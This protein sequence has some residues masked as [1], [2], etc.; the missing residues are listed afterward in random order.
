MSSAGKATLS[1]EAKKANHIASEQKRR[2]Q[3][4]GEMDR[5]ARAVG[6]E[7][8]GRNELKVYQ[9]AVDALT[10]RQVPRFRLAYENMKR[11]AVEPPDFLLDWYE[12]LGPEGRELWAAS[13]PPQK[14]GP[15]PAKKGP[16]KARKVASGAKATGKKVQRAG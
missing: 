12:S 11:D 15:Q 9:T 4:R 7:G 3:L 2:N 6:I 10:G 16:A 1:E 13:W 5:L 8:Q 14:P